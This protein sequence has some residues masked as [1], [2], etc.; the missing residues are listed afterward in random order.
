MSA[1]MR[2]DGGPW[3]TMRHEGAPP[4]ERQGGLFSTWSQ[5]SLWSLSV[6][7]KIL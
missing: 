4:G 1:I 7:Y 5:I 2:V 6:S 3:T